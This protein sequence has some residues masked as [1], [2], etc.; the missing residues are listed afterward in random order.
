[1]GADPGVLAV[2]DAMTHEVWWTVGMAGT[3][4]QKCASS[5][6]SWSLRAPQHHAL[7]SWRILQITAGAVAWDLITERP[8]S[9]P[10]STPGQ[11]PQDQHI[12]IENG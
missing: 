10:P 5:S 4:L 12:H 11:L 8:E 1:M 7:R 9:S 6:S 3:G 2:A